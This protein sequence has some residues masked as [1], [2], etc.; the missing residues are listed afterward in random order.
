M[1]VTMDDI[2]QTFTKDSILKKF[3][4]VR[5]Q[6]LELIEPLEAEDMV[7]QTESFVSPIKWHLGHTTWFFEKFL[8]I[9][10]LKNY[11]SF[12]ESFDYIFNSYYLGVGSFNEKSKRG[13]LNRPLYKRVLEYRKYVDSYMNDLL[14]LKLSRDLNFKVELG[15]NHE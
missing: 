4:A 3:H 10:N 7:V 8:L 12:D 9:P 11:I 1:L 5:K 2:S 14:N 6:S 13:F 15:I